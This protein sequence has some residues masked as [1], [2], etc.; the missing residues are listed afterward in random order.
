[1]TKDS[2]LIQL[3]NAVKSDWLQ[4]CNAARIPDHLSQNDMDAILDVKVRWDRKMYGKS[5]KSIR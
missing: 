1:M 4:L 5:F 2:G 3:A